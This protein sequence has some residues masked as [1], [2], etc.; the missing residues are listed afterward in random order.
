MGSCAAGPSPLRRRR[1]PELDARQRGADVGRLLEE[2]VEARYE[3]RAP[4]VVLH[5][6]KEQPALGGDYALAEG[7]ELGDVRRVDEPDA[8]KVQDDARARRQ[9]VEADH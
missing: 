5:V 3:E 8:G 9:R 6:A 1:Q 4:D 2:L 7:E